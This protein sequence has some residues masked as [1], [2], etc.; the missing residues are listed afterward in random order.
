MAEVS[1][2]VPDS[3]CEFLFVKSTFVAV[4]WE[5]TFALLV[6]SRSPV[7]IISCRLLPAFKLEPEALLWF[8]RSS[9]LLP[10]S[11]TQ[12]VA[13]CSCTCSRSVAGVPADTCH[14]KR[15]TQWKHTQQ[16][17]T[18]A[19][20]GQPLCLGELHCVSKAYGSAVLCGGPARACFQTAM[21]SSHVSL[22]YFNTAR[23]I[24]FLCL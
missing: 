14:W 8:P 10:V 11:R 18:H 9:C 24:W 5:G 20:G 7:I 21:A 16:M 19:P 12:L 2:H 3:F 13:T 4:R 15:I 22:L 1:K 23:E 6:H 17:K